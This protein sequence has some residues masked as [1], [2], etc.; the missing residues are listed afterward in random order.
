MTEKVSKYRNRC[1]EDEGFKDKV[2]FISGGTGFMGKVFVEKILRTCPSVNKI[3]LLTREKKGKSPQDRLKEIFAG[4][5]FD[6]LKKTQGEEILDKVIA[7]R[8]DVTEDNLGLTP[9]LRKKLV[10][11][12][13][14]IFHMAATIRFDDPLKK[15][16]LLNVR[17]TKYMLDF[18]KEC[19]HLLVF[20]HI[21][22][23]Y[24][25]LKEKVLYEK[26]YPP[27]ADPHMLIKLVEWL[28]EAIVDSITKQILDDYPNTYA[29]TKS[30]SESLVNDEMDNLPVIILRP[31]VV[32]PIWKDPLPGWTDNINGP[33]GLL[34]AAG[35]GIL[36]S[37]YCDSQGYADFLPVDVAV[38]VLILTCIDYMIYRK[39]RIYNCTSSFEY[40]VTWEEIIEMGRRIIEYRLPLNGVVWYPGGSMKSSRLQHYF[41]V[42]F[43]HYLPAIVLDALI[44]L[45]G[46]KPVL[47][48]VQQRIT[49][50]F[51]I[52]EYY[53]NNQW[54]F[55]N[56]ESLTARDLMTEKELELY[57]VDGQGMDMDE[58]FYHCTHAAR[59][60]ILKEGDETIPAAKRHMKMY[61]STQKNT[62][63]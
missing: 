51:D 20:S 52:F 27:P 54:D 58:Y 59:L 26:P 25:H 18:A 40:K 21:S 17:G 62:L 61:V 49:K 48:K 56:D 60:Y 45:S 30:L 35:K 43:F 6:L 4:P 38:N 10:E 9:Q 42:L 8:G 53:A 11:E 19:K 44:F 33:T 37:M 7:V 28:D 39:R 23:A 16:V 41:C 63:N 29:F 57:K 13:D 47:W 5:L 50:G 3:Y 14:V 2:L 12:V 36:R 55:V 34:I 22:T 32:I 24:C 31:S 15:A 1:N 46:N